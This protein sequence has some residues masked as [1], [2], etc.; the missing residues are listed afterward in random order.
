MTGQ[1]DKDPL[2]ILKTK[3]LSPVKCFNGSVMKNKESIYSDEGEQKRPPR[4]P[5]AE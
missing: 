3:M 1:S 4:V 5:T 2:A